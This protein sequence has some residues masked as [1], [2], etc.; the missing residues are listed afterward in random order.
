MAGVGVMLVLGM[1]LGSCRCI[2]R[3]GAYGEVVVAPMVMRGMKDMREGRE[4]CWCP[5]C[6][7]GGM[8]PGMRRVGAGAGA[9]VVMLKQMVVM[10]VSG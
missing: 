9:G 5:D 1:K 7:G 4:G 6:G 10:L 8:V 2:G 3:G